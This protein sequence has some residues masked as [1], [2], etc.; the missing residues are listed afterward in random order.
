MTTRAAPSIGTHRTPGA[1]TR[2]E[3]GARKPASSAKLK[4]S[5]KAAKD[6]EVS[7][8]DYGP[9]T[10]FMLALS[11]AIAGGGATWPDLQRDMSAHL[12]Q[13][14]PSLQLSFRDAVA[15]AGATTR[16]PGSP[17]YINALKQLRTLT[18]MLSILYLQG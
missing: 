6:L 15:K 12:S 10:P 1:D 14:P 2:T 13:V 3:D 11:S 18:M 17:A 4:E 9:L 8:V 5:R 7:L 16:L